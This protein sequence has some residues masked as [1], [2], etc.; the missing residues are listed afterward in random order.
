MLFQHSLNLPLKPSLV[1]KA[2]ICALLTSAT[3]AAPIAASAYGYGDSITKS[4]HTV[5]FNRAEMKTPEGVASVYAKLTK[6]AKRACAFGSNVDSDGKKISNEVC[7]Q[8]LLAQFIESA[9]VKPLQQYHLMKDARSK[10]A[11]LMPR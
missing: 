4:V 9:K 10:S 7:T 3:M 5:K 2:V 6:K 8:E 11:S 1:N